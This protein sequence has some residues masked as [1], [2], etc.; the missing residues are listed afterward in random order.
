MKIVITTGYTGGHIYPAIALGEYLARR[1][2][3]IDIL[4]I[5]SNR[6]RSTKDYFAKLSLGRVIY[7]EDAPFSYRSL[8]KCVFINIK[9]FIKAHNILQYEKPDVVIGFGSYLSFPLVLVAWVFRIKTV[10]HEQNARFGKAN[11]IL[12]M[13]ATKVALSYRSTSKGKNTIVTGNLLRESVLDVAARTISA[14]QFTHKDIYTVLVLGGSQGATAINALMLEVIETL[15]PSQKDRIRI[16]LIS[17][18]RDHQDIKARLEKTG[19]HFVLFPFTEDIPLLYEKADIVLARAG[20]GVVFECLAFG[21]PAIFIPYPYAGSHQK[22]N[23]TM[24][25]REGAAILLEQSGLTAEHLKTVLFELINDPAKLE[26]MSHNASRL[27]QIEGCR[28]L[29][30]T[31]STLV[32]GQRR[33]T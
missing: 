14:K 1:H 9:S 31:L 10:I 21:L 30:E 32:K 15:Q 27:K 11:K 16:L 2:Q 22:D 13:F 17:G 28:I 8:V 3:D 23:V 24:L 26:T 33:N 12:A 5:A 7:F 18:E 20:S 6:A 29:D 19:V 25:E 4:Y